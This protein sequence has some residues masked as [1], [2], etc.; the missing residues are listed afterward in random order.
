M[1]DLREWLEFVR[2]LGRTRYNLLKTTEPLLF[3][4]TPR[5]KDVDP[6]E[7]L[8]RYPSDIYSHLP[9]LYMLSVEMKLRTM[10][11]LGTR[12]GVSTTALLYAAEEIGGHVYSFDI[13][14]CVEAK[15]AV[16]SLGLQAY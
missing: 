1:A 4:Q 15:K 10:V 12:T 16:Q 3:R 13:D 5:P 8:S 11:E 2:R 6:L 7:Y 14:P 9:T